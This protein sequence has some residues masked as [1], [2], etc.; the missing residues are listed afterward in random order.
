MGA[1]GVEGT[2]GAAAK[3]DE[4][5]YIGLDVMSERGRWPSHVQP[6]SLH[7][8]PQLHTVTAYPP[9]S[10]GRSHRLFRPRSLSRSHSAYMLPIPRYELSTR[11]SHH[12]RP[13]PPGPAASPS[14]SHPDCI[15]HS[16]S[17]HSV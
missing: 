7:H 12:S 2:G 6:S 15:R 17:I 16:T 8:L 11:P 4:G 3:R 5:G 1:G 13:I 9:I 10:S 14:T